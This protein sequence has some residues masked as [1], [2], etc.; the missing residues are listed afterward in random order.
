MRLDPAGATWLETGPVGGVARR[1]RQLAQ[2]CRKFVPSAYGNGPT[3]VGAE[4]ILRN[5]R[6]SGLACRA[7]CFVTAKPEDLAAR[8]HFNIRTSL[9]Q[10]G[11]VLA[12]R[13]SPTNH[14]DTLAAE[15]AQIRVLDDDG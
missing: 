3:P 1:L 6:N 15:L 13:L 9:A 4:I 7:A 12:S 5:R 2:K 10:D 11:S 8:D 14:A